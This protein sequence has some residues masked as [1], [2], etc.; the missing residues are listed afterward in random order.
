MCGTMGDPQREINDMENEKKQQKVWYKES[1]PGVFECHYTSGHRGKER[2]PIVT[3]FDCQALGN[4]EFWEMLST[5]PHVQKLFIDGIKLFRKIQI[6]E[7]VDAGETRF[8]IVLTDA[9]FARTRTAKPATP[10][11]M[12]KSYKLLSPE[13]QEAFRLEAGIDS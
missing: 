9:D 3:M 4:V 2:T 10:Q 11:N 6:G 7:R 1:S 13:Q 8:D 12:G 5:F